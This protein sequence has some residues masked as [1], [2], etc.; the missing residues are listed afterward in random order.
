MMMMMQ[1][2]CYCYFIVA[3]VWV[4]IGESAKKQMSCKNHN[5][6]CTHLAWLEN[7][8]YKDGVRH[9]CECEH[10]SMC[11]CTLTYS[12]MYMKQCRNYTGSYTLYHKYTHHAFP[13]LQCIL[14][15]MFVKPLVNLLFSS[16]Y[17]R[18]NNAPFTHDCIHLLLYCAYIYKCDV[19]SVS[20][21][22]CHT[23]L[24]ACSQALLI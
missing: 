7:I 2:Q 21:Y 23:S 9:E 5:V 6:T 14:E 20:I 22:D 13:S 10:A 17:Y 15:D 1:Q 3:E 12:I 4:V 24:F 16:V 8:T 18:C 11:M 19:M